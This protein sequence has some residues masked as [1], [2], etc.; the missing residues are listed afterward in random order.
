MCWC[1]RYITFLGKG[2][3]SHLKI[4]LSILDIRAPS[5]G[6]C[7]IGVFRYLGILPRSSGLDGLSRL[8]LYCWCVSS[9]ILFCGQSIRVLLC[10]VDLEVELLLRGWSL[11]RGLASFLIWYCICVPVGCCMSSHCMG[12]SVVS[13][14]M[15]CL[16]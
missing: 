1:P 13:M 7:T 6:A 3:L 4:P 14:T 12:V 15:C 8:R 5:L 16:V 11:G 10:W 9:L 2:V